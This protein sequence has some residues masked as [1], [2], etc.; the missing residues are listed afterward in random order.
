MAL[1]PQ[2]INELKAKYNIGGQPQSTGGNLSSP[3]DRIRNLRQ[4][5]ITGGKP[6]ESKG[7]FNKFADASGSALKFG[8]ENFV[9]PVAR[10]LMRPVVGLTKGVQS[11]VPG[12]KTGFEDVKTPFG[13]MNAFPT[14]SESVWET[15]DVGTSLIPFDE[16]ARAL[17]P[18]FEPVKEMASKV[19]SG[20]KS[21]K[22][23]EEMIEK[24]LSNVGETMTGVERGR[25]SRWYNLMKANP[26]KAEKV[27]QMITNNPQQ[28]FRPLAEDISKN[29]VDMKTKARTAFDEAVEKSKIANPNKKYNLY[30][31]IPKVSETVSKYNLAIEAVKDKAGNVV[32]YAVRPTTR[33]SPFKEQEIE[34]LQ[35]LVDKM[36]IRDMSVDE[37][38]DV[39]KAFNKFFDTAVVERNKT[40]QAIGYDLVGKSRDFIDEALPEVNDANEMYRDYY[41]TK[42]ALSPIID[43]YDEVKKGAESFLSNVYNLNKG[44]ER[45]DMMNAARKL[46]IDILDEARTIKDAMSLMELIPNTTKSRVSAIVRGTATALGV[47]SLNPALAIPALMANVMSSPQAYRNLIEIIAGKKTIGSMVK[48]AKDS[49]QL[50]TAEKILLQNI[51]KGLA[52][53]GVRE[54]ENTEGKI[55][56]ADED[57]DL[58]ID[59]KKLMGVS[60][61]TLGA[62]NP[63]GMITNRALSQAITKDLALLKYTPKPEQAAMLKS[64]GQGVVPEKL[65]NLRALFSTKGFNVNSL[66]TAILPMSPQKIQEMMAK[67]L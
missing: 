58:G 22:P 48:G 55:N 19:K 59:F 66:G 54:G 15:I 61:G 34:A 63:T 6:K 29:L 8:A 39:D 14:T 10:G 17:K 4:S 41:E 25:I 49:I 16:F 28:P 67:G 57:I 51:I 40:L 30:N 2:Q 62:S 35:E 3:E 47:G 44:K 31:K 46:G 1:T 26:E 53:S 27:K 50:N 64:L 7:F 60:A 36:N 38:M 65:K 45:A 43:K 37:L 32:D 21:L 13:T 23:S 11:L 9:N 56:K 5:A 52:A 12:G 20:F 18:V 24:T 42:K 33:T